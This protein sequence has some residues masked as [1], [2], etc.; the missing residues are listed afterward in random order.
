MRSRFNLVLLLLLLYTLTLGCTVFCANDLDA[1]RSGSSQ[2]QASQN[3][4]SNGT[5][6]ESFDS[7][8]DYM[9]NH[10]AVTSEDMAKAKKMT[11]PITKLI[12]TLIGI[13]MTITS[14]LIFLVTA[15]DLMY[16]AVPFTRSFLNPAGQ[17]SGGIG[18]MGMGGMGGMRGGMGGMGAMGGGG[19]PAGTKKWVSDEAVA[20]LMATQPQ[21]GGGMGGMGMGMGGM[22][23]MGGM[24]PNQA[25]A[26][27]K[28]VIGA[29]FK[30]RIVFIVIFAIA[31]VILMSSLLTDCGLN[32]AELLYKIGA[33]FNGGISNVDF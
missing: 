9:R 18:G 25:P 19:Q 15:L 8:S 24:N 3:A 7:I 23:A 12:G 31:S 27:S 32:L 30:K 28:S 16:I 22:G 4:G 2:S 6:D 14:T 17:V 26:G 10:D 13:I 29:Y 20:A 33:M 11:S 21:Q 5:G 1:I